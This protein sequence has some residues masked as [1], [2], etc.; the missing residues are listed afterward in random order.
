[1]P[2]HSSM[3]DRLKNGQINP[4]APQPKR[5]EEIFAGTDYPMTFDGFVGQDLAVE[6]LQ[7]CIHSAKARGTRLDHTLLASGA[8][9]I[10]KTTLAQIIA[11][12][13]GA[14][15]VAISGPVSVDDARTILMGMQDGDVLFWDEFHLAV[16]GNKNRADWLLPFLTDRELL[17]KR[18]TEQMPDVTVLA[19]TTDVGR[20][21]QT[22]ISRFMIRPRLSYYSLEEAT[23]ICAQLTGRMKVRISS[24]TALT[25][26]AR[27]ANH[28]PREMRMILTAV[29]DL[30]MV[31]PVNLDKAFEWAGLT[32][33]GLS[34]E[35]QEILLILLGSTAYTASLETI[36]AALGEPG[37]LKHHE[38]AMIQ[39]GLITIGGRGRTL[40]DLGVERAQLLLLER[41]S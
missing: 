7:I 8:H 10:G 6:Q 17:T 29:R 35:C 34:T 26:I 40:T 13:L 19:A 9:G 31:G 25:R 16:A 38:Q 15:F 41:A 30:A 37:P 1:M 12:E 2:L 14:G 32:Y 23:K 36:Q 5:G 20:L 4:N 11:Y 18:G 27:A 3:T 33:D 28:N 21:P 22:I 39:K 24:E